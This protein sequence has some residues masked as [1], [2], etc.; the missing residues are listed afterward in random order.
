MTVW[1]YKH[2]SGIKIEFSQKSNYVEELRGGNLYVRLRSAGSLVQV[3]LQV[4]HIYMY[5]TAH[6]ME[7]MGSK[8]NMYLDSGFSYV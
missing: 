1:V 5:A 3:E 8:I 2:V 6:L 7:Q 4:R